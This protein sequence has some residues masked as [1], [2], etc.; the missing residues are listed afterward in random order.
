MNSVGTLK[1]DQKLSK[2]A[3]SNTR[4][5]PTVNN[6]KKL[7]KLKVI[8]EQNDISKSCCKWFKL[9]FQFFLFE[10]NLKNGGARAKKRKFWLFSQFLPRRLQWKNY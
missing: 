9:L 3:F 7:K 8:W 2:K 5:I 1:F 6:W 4:A 10:R